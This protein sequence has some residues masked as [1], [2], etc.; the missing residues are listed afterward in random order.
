MADANEW[1]TIRKKFEEH[2]APVIRNELDVQAFKETM[3]VLDKLKNTFT[4]RSFTQKEAMQI[5]LQALTLEAF[6]RIGRM[7]R[8]IEH[9]KDFENI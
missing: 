8:R 2:F 3:D 5:F 6:K 9:G 1:D 7:E 4:E